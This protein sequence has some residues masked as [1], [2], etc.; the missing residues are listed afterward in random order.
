MFNGIGREGA[1]VVLKVSVVVWSTECDLALG[2][3]RCKFEFHAEDFRGSLVDAFVRDAAWVHASPT[4][5][6]VTFN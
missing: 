5:F 2:A 1:E 3:I 6:S 4:V